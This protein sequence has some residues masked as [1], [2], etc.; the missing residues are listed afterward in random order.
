MSRQNNSKI[1]ALK[2]GYFAEQGVKLWFWLKRYRLLFHRWTHKNGEIDLI[3]LKKDTLIFIEVKF[4]SRPENLEHALSKVQYERLKKGMLLFQQ[5]HP[6][7]RNYAVR[8]DMVWISGKNWPIHL[9]N[10]W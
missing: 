1:V 9:K 5:R 8:F 2:K 7:Y 10:I 3:F 6:H 4:R